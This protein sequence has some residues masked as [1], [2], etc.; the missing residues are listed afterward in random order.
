MPD[1]L[2]DPETGHRGRVDIS[3]MTRRASWRRGAGTILVAAPH[4]PAADQTDQDSA[5]HDHDRRAEQSQTE[6]RQ[7]RHTRRRYAAWMSGR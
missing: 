2:A 6:P 5:R 1:G 7:V 3:R 4:N